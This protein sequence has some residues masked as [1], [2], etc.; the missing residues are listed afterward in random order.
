[1]GKI[2]EFDKKYFGTKV[3]HTY[4]INEAQI[5]LPEGVEIKEGSVVRLESEYCNVTL[6]AR[7]G[8]GGQGDIYECANRSNYVIKILNDKSRTTYYEKKLSELIKFSNTNNQICWPK[9]VVTKDGV[10]I[11]F[12]MPK[13]V[14][15][16]LSWLEHHTSAQIL[17]RYPNFDRK[18]QV[19][20]ILD[21]LKQFDYLHSKNILVGDVK[22]E[23]IMFD[24]KT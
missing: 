5:Q 2:V 13:V 17:K 19:K 10:F 7:L 22:L 8:F 1:M 6:G 14:G 9:D 15:N 20:I 4:L 24:E 3:T 21:V 12:L 18:T 11:G 16:N 23:N